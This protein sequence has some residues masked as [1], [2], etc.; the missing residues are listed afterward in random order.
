VA[1]L[2]WTDESE[3]NLAAIQ[4]F[5]ASDNEAAANRV[6]DALVKAA[7]RLRDFP[8]LGRPV[9]ELLAQGVREL[10]VSPYRIAYRED[11]NI[12]L[13]LKVWHGR[14]LLRAEDI[15]Q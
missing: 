14:R 5:I 4:R 15:V 6:V 8:Q 10:I 3:S 1:E 9:E 2:V 7:E 13:I 12:V 11:G